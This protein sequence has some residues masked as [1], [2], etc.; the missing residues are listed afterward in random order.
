M[1]L[2]TILKEIDPYAFEEAMKMNKEV[3]KS[4]EMKQNEDDRKRFDEQWE[5]LNKQLKNKDAN[6]SEPDLPF[7]KERLISDYNE[8]YKKIY[9]KEKFVNL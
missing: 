5:K 2:K 9:D 1:A 3:K 7:V 4:F 6:Y 8:L